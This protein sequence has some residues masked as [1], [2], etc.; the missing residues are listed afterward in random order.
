MTTAPRGILWETLR[1]RALFVAYYDGPNPAERWESFVAALGQNQ[2]ELNP[3]ALVYA[4]EQPPL[5]AIESMQHV[6]RGRRW[7]VAFVSPSI[8]VRFV[9]STFALTVRDVRFFSPDA[10]PAALKHL[11][12]T[13]QEEQLV[14]IALERLRWGL[15][16]G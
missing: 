15:A 4:L 7:R 2:N 11:E 1:E 16:S 10:L 3:R 12:C 14:L 8:A 5:T 9:A 13:G 6:M